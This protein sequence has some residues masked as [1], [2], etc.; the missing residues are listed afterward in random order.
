MN[1]IG[2]GESAAQPEPASAIKAAASLVPRHPVESLGLLGT[3][4]L[5]L[6]SIGLQVGA[7][8]VYCAFIPEAVRR[9]YEVAAAKTITEPN[10]A[11]ASAEA[12]LKAHTQ[13][14]TT[15]L[16]YDSLSTTAAATIAW[17]VIGFVLARSIRTVPQVFAVVVLAGLVD[18]GAFLV[19]VGLTLGLGSEPSAF[20]LRGLLGHSL[21]LG[22]I[23]SLSVV[24]LWWCL[25]LAAGLGRVWQLPKPVV[26]PLVFGF[27]ILWALGTNLWH[28]LIHSTLG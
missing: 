27:T 14:Y 18:T 22:P 7:Y 11:K 13:R 26:V 9:S 16:I 21:P 3:I 5:L 8:R 10:A 19:R 4:G 12:A 1:T 20:T 23:G 2:V 6:V 25:V 17:C 15:S 28:Q 24:T